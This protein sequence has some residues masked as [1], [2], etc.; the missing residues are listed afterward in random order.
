MYVQKGY[1]GNRL[2]YV[3]DK[4]KRGKVTKEKITIIHDI[5]R[6]TGQRPGERQ[7]DSQAG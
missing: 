6:M 7:M 1:A 2:L 4:D 5:R 3:K